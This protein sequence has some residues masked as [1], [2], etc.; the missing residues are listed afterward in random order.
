MTVLNLLLRQGLSC[1]QNEVEGCQA[2]K[3]TS[4]LPRETSA[5]SKYLHSYKVFSSTLYLYYT[6]INP[7]LQGYDYVFHQ[8]YDVSLVFSYATYVV[9]C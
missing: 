6:E 4:I 1:F 8:N 7:L 9:V 2:L 5:G 3:S